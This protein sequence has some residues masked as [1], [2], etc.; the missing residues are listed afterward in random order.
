MEQYWKGSNN[1]A[2]SHG[3]NVWPKGVEEVLGVKIGGKKV[4]VLGGGGAWD[5]WVPCPEWAEEE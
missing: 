4:E 2:G 3:R 1:M 5:A